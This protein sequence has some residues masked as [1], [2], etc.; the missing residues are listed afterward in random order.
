MDYR[1]ILVAI[2]LSTVMVGAVSADIISISPASV[3]MSNYPSLRAQGLGNMGVA[4]RD[5][6][7]FTVNPASLGAITG[8]SRIG[9]FG[10]PVS[11]SY[12]AL[13]DEYSNISLGVSAVATDARLGVDSPWS[14]G[15]G[16]CF[17]RESFG[18][19]VRT[20]EDGSSLEEFDNDAKSHGIVIAAGYGGA[21]SL[22]AGIAY[23]HITAHLEDPGA[24]LELGSADGNGNLFDFGLHA[25]TQTNLLTLDSPEGPPTY[26]TARPMMGV[27][28]R[29]IGA[30]FKYLDAAQ[31]DE[32]PRT[33]RIGAAVELVRRR[34]ELDVIT[35]TPVFELEHLLTG[36]GNSVFHYGAEVAIAEII[37]GRIADITDDDFDQTTWGLTA[38]TA[39]LTKILT[40]SGEDK[41]LWTRTIL[42][43]SLARY[44]KTGDSI[45]RGGLLA[46][47]ALR[48]LI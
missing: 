35:V 5:I 19:I 33:V 37:T 7:S 41:S 36:E 27:T 14:I 24:G 9:L 39:G 23:R 44:F 25:G 48:Y 12:E 34:G 47:L 32:P 45:F 10:N 26:V 1:K 6:Q 29:N 15:I 46:G 43:I 40:D 3:V 16:Y 42:E 4:L 8:P 38:S 31:A 11:D 22:G 21:V 13:P 18:A 30:D 2:L 28:F 20:A 17:Q